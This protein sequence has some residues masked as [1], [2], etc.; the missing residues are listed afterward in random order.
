MRKIRIF[1]K[2]KYFLLGIWAFFRKLEEKFSAVFSKLHIK[3]PEKTLEEIV[4]FHNFIEFPIF[5]FTSRKEIVNWR[6]SF[7]QLL[8][9]EFHVSRETF[10]GKLSLKFFFSFSIFLG[11][12]EK[13]LILAKNFWQG[14]WNC[15][16]IDPRTF[17]KNVFRLIF[18]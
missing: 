15:S 14:C 17:L 8:K 5:F 18:F 11:L 4:S 16:S 2:K 1:V 7:N 3:C 12:W 9:I 6:K 10:G 13:T